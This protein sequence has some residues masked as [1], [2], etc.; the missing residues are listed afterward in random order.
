VLTVTL[1]ASLLLQVS[2]PP[3]DGEGFDAPRPL[4]G[5]VRSLILPGWGQLDSQRSIGWVPFGLEAVTWTAFALHR[6]NAQSARIAYRDLA[7]ERARTPSPGRT[8]QD[9]DW[10]Y[11]ER[12]SRWTASGR[13]NR[14]S[15]PQS[16]LPESD[17]ATYNGS[18]WRLAQDLYLPVG[19]EQARPGD[20]GWDRAVAYY[21]SRAVGPDFEWDWGDA[22]GSWSRFQSL[23]RDSDRAYRASTTW[24]GVAMLN[25]FL[26][27]AEQWVAG[28]EPSLSSL[29]LRIRARAD[30]QGEAWVHLSFPLFAPGQRPSPIRCRSSGD[31]CPRLP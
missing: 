30:L 24:V 23:I 2:V 21:Q 18:I 3:E 16:F 19:G 7:W 5:V 4:E 10:A 1:F 25:R 26:S 17:E 13:F 14:S 12:M 11:Y 28:Q 29:P 15:D 9:G 20:P 27:A 31:L 22:R 8:R 6:Q